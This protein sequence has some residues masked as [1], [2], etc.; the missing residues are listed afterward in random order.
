MRRISERAIPC[1]YVVQETKCLPLFCHLSRLSLTE[2]ITEDRPPPAPTSQMS[3]TLLH[4]DGG[5]GGCPAPGSTRQGRRVTVGTGRTSH[6]PPKLAAG[7]R[8][9]VRRGAADVYGGAVQPL[10]G[11][12]WPR[13]Y[14]KPQPRRPFLTPGFPPQ[15]VDHRR[16]TSSATHF[17]NPPTQTS[18]PRAPIAIGCNGEHRRDA[19]LEASDHPGVK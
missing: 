12:A 3:R 19:D 17:P 8:R 1:N 16:Q 15:P 11:G 7:R 6:G 2:Q 13:P 10:G 14:K 9:C 4:A 5:A 18:H